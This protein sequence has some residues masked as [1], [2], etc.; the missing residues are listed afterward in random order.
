MEAFEHPIAAPA[1]S[2]GYFETRSIALQGADDAVFD[3]FFASSSYQPYIRFTR[4]EHI[5]VHVQTAE[6]GRILLHF[7]DQSGSHASIT[8]V[9]IELQSSFQEVV[10]ASIVT[11]G[12]AAARL[13]TTPGKS[14]RVIALP[15][16]RNYALIVLESPPQEIESP[17]ERL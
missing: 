4:P 7:R 11:P 9:K 12:T 16:F 8:D 13:N 15:A 5:L 3:E 6:D 17:G 1:A 2:Q 14:S 10:C